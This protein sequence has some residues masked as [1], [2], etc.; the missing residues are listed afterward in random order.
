VLASE[1]G[2]DSNGE[3][4]SISSINIHLYAYQKEIKIFIASFTASQNIKSPT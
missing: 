4:K 2:L 1:L 3:L